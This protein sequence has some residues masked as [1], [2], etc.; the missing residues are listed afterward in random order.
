MNTPFRFTDLAVNL[1]KQITG[2]MPKRVEIWEPSET[3]EDNIER[4]HREPH[5]AD[6]LREGG[7][8]GRHS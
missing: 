8:A 3:D 2:Q 1:G 4:R 5:D 6:A 7:N